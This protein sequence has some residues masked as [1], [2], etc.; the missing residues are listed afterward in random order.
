ME[1][2]MFMAVV[3]AGLFAGFVNTLAGSGS[4]I[5]LPL[6]MFLGLPANIAN[7]TNRIGVLVQS[8]VSSW[9]FKKQKLYTARE[10]LWMVIPAVVGSFLGSLVAI[11]INERIME[12]LIG[13]L[14]IFMFFVIL[15]K[16]EKWVREHATAMSVRRKWWV[17][18][19]FFFIGIY[20]GFIQAG[21]GFFL[22][23]ALVLGAGLGLTKAN[24]LKVVIVAA[25]TLV[26]LIVFIT[27]GQVNYLYGITLAIGQGAG[28]WLA[29]KVAV[30]WG[31]RVVRI[32]LLIAVM[33]SALK[34]TGAIDF[35]I[36]LF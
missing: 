15:Y 5:T 6:L 8:A 27:S 36:G 2:Y 21:V 7:G 32:I 22:L 10:S 34:L 13:G 29:S 11:R 33:A 35:L 19:I 20:G 30:S 16:P 17:S 1:W 23:A 28:G 9:S 25:L 18:V 12:L 31:P 24:A 26:A 14:L 4:L 3:A